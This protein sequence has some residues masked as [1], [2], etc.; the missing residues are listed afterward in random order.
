MATL[1]AVITG[2][3]RK[4]ER[5]LDVPQ[6]HQLSIARRTMAQNC[7]AARMLGG[8]NHYEAARIIHE[9]TGVFVGIDA[10]CTC[11]KLSAS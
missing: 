9:L 6:R 2:A 10:P 8:P 1:N 3:V 4:R 7:F 5:A 11:S